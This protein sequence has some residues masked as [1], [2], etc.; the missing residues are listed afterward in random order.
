MPAKFSLP[1]ATAAKS[2]RKNF[3]SD[4][5][6]LHKQSQDSDSLYLTHLTLSEMCISLGQSKNIARRND[7]RFW[8]S[9]GS[10]ISIV[11]ASVTMFLHHL[12]VLR[13]ACSVCLYTHLS[14]YPSIY[15][16]SIH[17]FICPS[18]GLHICPSS[19]F[20]ICFFELTLLPHAPNPANECK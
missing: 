16:L 13:V 6:Q 8:R 3:G 15:Y 17:L 2:R 11:K 12:T 1:V 10:S 5:T 9:Q 4:S 7:S 20:M 18:I 19:D 14:D